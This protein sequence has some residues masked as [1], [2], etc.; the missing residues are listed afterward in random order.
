MESVSLVTKIKATFVIDFYL[1]EVGVTFSIKHLFF[2]E[3]VTIC[4]MFCRKSQS[5]TQPF[6]KE[7]WYW[8]LWYQVC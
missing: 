4:T 7:S 2:L 8:F 3:H 1:A 6:V 5:Y